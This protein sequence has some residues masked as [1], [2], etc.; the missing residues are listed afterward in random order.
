MEGEPAEIVEE[1]ISD[2][3]PSMVFIND[4]IF[5]YGRKL[6]RWKELDSQ[7]VKRQVKD[8][9]A[10]EMVRCFRKLQTVLNSYTDL[11]SKLLQTQKVATA[12]R[13]GNAAIIELEKNDIS[14]M[15]SS[16]GRL[17]TDS[18]GQSAGWNQ[19]EESSRSVTDRD[20]D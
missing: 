2:T 16:C 20:T 13:I 11:R 3:L 15:E 10:A 18:T 1:N 9:E 12:E 6:E 4:R 7:S 19:R 5:E 14:F 8:D 17:L